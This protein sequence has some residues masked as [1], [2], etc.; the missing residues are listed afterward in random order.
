VLRRLLSIAG[1]Y[2]FAA[3]SVSAET[4][5]VFSGSATC[6]E[7]DLSFLITLTRHDRLDPSEFRDPCRSGSGPCNDQIRETFKLTRRVTG[8]ATIATLN[9]M[10]EVETKHYTLNGTAVDIPPRGWNRQKN[11][12]HDYEFEGFSDAS[13]IHFKMFRYTDI[14]DGEKKIVMHWRGEPCDPVRI[15]WRALAAPIASS[16]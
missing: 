2:L 15:D 11:M 10:N 14:R 9:E 12:R 16:Q 6:T 5:E 13:Y 7:H 4:H 3:F 1:I 8:S